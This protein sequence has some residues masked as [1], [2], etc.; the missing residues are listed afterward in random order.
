MRLVTL[1]VLSLRELWIS[2]RLLVLLAVPL[3]GGLLTAVVPGAAADPRWLAWGIAGAGV[4]V[5]AIAATSLAAQRRRGVAGWLVLR[6][7]PRSSL[8]IAWFVAIALPALVATAAGAVVGWLALS[9]TL[10]LLDPLAFAALAAAATV[11][12]LEALAIGLLAGAIASP[13]LALAI[14]A[15]LSAGGLAAGLLAPIGPALWPTSG[16]Q[17]LAGA[18]ALDRPF[19]SGVQSLGLGLAATGLLVLLASAAFSRVDL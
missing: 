14:A 10:P 4:I 3:V 12:L 5:A 1:S 19:S 15:A 9:A 11:S 17:L 6:A 7:V 18:G 16:L 2:Y 13:L 8:V